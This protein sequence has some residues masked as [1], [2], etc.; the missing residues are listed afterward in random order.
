MKTKNLL[1][2]RKTL[3]IGTHCQT[4]LL[5]ISKEVH[6]LNSSRLAESKLYVIK[7]TMLRE[8]QFAMHYKG[9]MEVLLLK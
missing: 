1:K 6:F 5:F 9:F 3:K 4:T 8:K 7:R 2:N